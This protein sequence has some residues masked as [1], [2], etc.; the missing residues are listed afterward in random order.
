MLVYFYDGYNI[1]LT[2]LFSARQF[3]S[4]SDYVPSV[5][6]QHI[7]QDHTNILPDCIV[8]I[9]K[10]LVRIQ[11]AS[12]HVSSSGLDVDRI[13]GRIVEN[14]PLFSV[15]ITVPEVVHDTDDVT[16][17]CVPTSCVAT[18]CDTL[19]YIVISCRRG[20]LYLVDE[21]QY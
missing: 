3:Q 10:E 11:V 19:M 21:H 14:A 13:T 7:P 9:M 17:S 16:M 15:P 8:K 2:D 4:Y 12:S 6:Y 18:S 5:D 1:V 20:S